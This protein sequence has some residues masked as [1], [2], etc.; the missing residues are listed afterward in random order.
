MSERLEAAVPH[1][2]TLREHAARGTLINGAFMSGLGVL[3]LLRGFVVAAFVTTADYGLWGVLIVS[4]GT[5]VLLKQVG[6]GDRFVAQDEPD[7]ELA[8]HR[9]FTLELLLTLAVSVLLL[10]LLPLFA[11]AYGQPELLAPGLVVIAALPAIALQTPVWV[12]Y[13]RMQFVRQRTLQAVEPVVGFAVTLGLAI[14]GAGY[15]AFVVGYFVGA[16][17]AALVALLAAPVRPRWSFDS[18]VLRSYAAFSWPLFL[19][20]LGGVVVA[21]A[22]V[23]GT[24]AHLGIAAVGALTLAITI[25]QFTARV[26]QLVTE[27]L[28]PAIC[29]VRDRTELLLES[30]VKSNRLALMWGVPFGLGVSLFCADLVAFGIG[31][32]WEPAIVLMQVFGVV[33][34]AGQV[35]FN[36]D[37]Y[38]RALG[39]TRPIATASLITAASFVTAGIPLVLAFGLRGVAAAIAVQVAVDLVL[40][41]WF[42][43][44]IFPGL[45]FAR[46]ALRGIAPTIPAVALVLIVRA[47]ETGERTLALAI[48]EAALFLLV[49]ALVTW[50]AERVLLREALGYLTGRRTARVAV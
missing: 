17:S 22:A 33:A 6:I 39:Q 15:W 32:K 10:A 14:A 4:I 40:R 20:A 25:T 9:A 2:R 18:S 42:L 28:Y 19:A 43:R 45:R 8:F 5:L 47:V 13:R 21:Q 7:Q 36:W 3:S 37:A 12:Y 31:E 11:L 30:F 24:E 27:T 44:R 38:F 16:W 46:H 50:F 26:D 1:G 35:G 41:A 29:A 49:T 48:G 23:F 34:A